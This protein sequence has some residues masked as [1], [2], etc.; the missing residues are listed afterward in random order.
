MISEIVQSVTDKSENGLS[1]ALKDDINQP[2][3]EFKY[4]SNLTNKNGWWN[5]ILFDDNFY[6]IVAEIAGVKIDDFSKHNTF[7]KYIKSRK[8]KVIQNLL[9]CYEK[10]IPWQNEAMKELA[11]KRKIRAKKA[12]HNG[13]LPYCFEIEKSYLIPIELNNIIKDYLSEN[14]MC[15]GGCVDCKKNKKNIDVVLSHKTSECNYRKCDECRKKKYCDKKLCD[16]CDKIK[17]SIYSECVICRDL[18]IPKIYRYHDENCC[19]RKD[20]TVLFEGKYYYYYDYSEI[21]H[22]REIDEQY[23]IY[24]DIYSDYDSDF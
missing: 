11:K 13:F 4:K 15:V 12:I 5:L 24:R 21:L 17:N 18:K 3:L 6:S 19:H 10:C 1:K 7:M 20:G 22:N 23:E 14:F 2:N 9:S 8:N 16:E